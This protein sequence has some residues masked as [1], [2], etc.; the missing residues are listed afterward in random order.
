MPNT[1]PQEQIV[2]V[3]G[4][5]IRVLKGGE[6]KPLVI[7]HGVEG[8]FG[9]CAY[10][11]GLA[12]QCTVYAPSLPG[13][14]QSQRP[15]W[16]ESFAD[17]SRFSLWLLQ[18]LG[19]EKASLLGY[20]M[21]GWLAA[22]M[23]AM[24]PQVVDRLVLIDAAGIQPQQAEITDIFLHGLDAT[25]QMA[26]F[27]AQQAP[28]H[29]TLFKRKLSPEERET[30]VQNQESAV[31]YCWRPYMYERSLPHLLPRLR[32]PTLVVWGQEDRLIPVECAELYR[33]A[34]PGARLEVLPQCGHYPHL[35]KTEQF[36]GLVRDFLK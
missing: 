30:R 32:M 35:E 14:D 11:R 22:E 18:Q 16:L 20:G 24:C 9:W 25:R 34:I 17:L 36:I 4:A 2:N 33:Q 6:G 27:D 21:G 19:L 13:F 31:R 28:E 3:S 15:E 1:D 8:S 12:Q 5:D 26:F 7:F 10:Q 29:D 23:A